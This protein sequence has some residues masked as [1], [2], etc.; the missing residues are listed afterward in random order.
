M[1]RIAFLL[2]IASLGIVP[3][4]Q[5]QDHVEV[6]GFAEY[7]KL[8]ATSSNFVQAWAAEPRSTS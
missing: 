4:A 5:A 1:K 6:G 2:I 3:I 8:G 7:F